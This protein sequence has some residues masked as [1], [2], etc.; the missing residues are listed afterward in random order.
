MKL[1]VQV[2]LL[3]T[4]QQAAALEATL[5]AA[6]RAA[7]LVAA[8]AFQQRCFR[9]FDLRKHTYDQIKADFGLAAQAAQHV[10]KKVCDA[11]RTLHANLAAGT[12]ASPDRH[13]GS[14][15]RPNRSPSGRW[16]PSPMTT[17][18]CPGSMMRGRCRSGRAPGG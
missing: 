17:G 2:K 6:N 3:P 12:W 11:Y 1:V 18:A 13:A 14:K 7:N 9:T 15:P 16:R 8:L 10:I 5:H 4:P